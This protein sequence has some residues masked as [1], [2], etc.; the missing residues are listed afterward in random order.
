MERIYEYIIGCSYRYGPL[1]PEQ[2]HPPS[3]IHPTKR[4]NNYAEKKPQG[5]MKKGP[6]MMENATRT[7]FS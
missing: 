7:S 3:M 5:L 2:V 6:M 4:N 1:K